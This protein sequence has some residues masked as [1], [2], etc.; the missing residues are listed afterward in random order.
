M[1][2]SGILVELKSISKSYN[3]NLVLDNINFKLETGTITTI[4]GQNGAGKTTLAKIIL[5]IIA[6][7]SGTIYIKNGIKVGYLPQQVNLNSSI[8]IT[9]DTL[10]NMISYSDIA[11]KINDFSDFIDYQAVKEKNIKDISHGE[12]Q[13]LL[14]VGTLIGSPGLVILDEPTQY[15]DVNAQQVFYA[16]I[17]K[18]KNEKN[19]TILIISH[20]LFAVMKN[21]DQVICLNHHV[22]CEDKTHDKTDMQKIDNNL[23]NSYSQV[24][25]YTHHHDH[26]H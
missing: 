9:G 7:T 24:G 1:S 17:N 15:L 12:L 10:L 2:N 20:D 8:P 16:K 4:I 14:L 18:I 6:P 22:C 13:K 21:A 3:N 25:L 26:K 11:D 19:L 23:E 5:K